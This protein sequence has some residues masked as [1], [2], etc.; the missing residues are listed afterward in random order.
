[1]LNPHLAT[2][3]NPLNTEHCYKKIGWGCPD[4]E[5]GRG[6]MRTLVRWF[7]ELVCHDPS[8]LV[9]YNFNF[10]ICVVG[11]FGYVDGAFAPDLVRCLSTVH[12]RRN[13]CGPL[14]EIEAAQRMRTS[15]SV[16]RRGLLLFIE[17]IRSFSGDISTPI[18]PPLLSA[19]LSAFPPGCP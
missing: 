19:A 11:V 4:L 13:P 17:L 5:S 8:H 18:R 6:T 1:M 14:G 9:T 10:S 3:Q 15:V 12:T 7:W 2:K 16:A